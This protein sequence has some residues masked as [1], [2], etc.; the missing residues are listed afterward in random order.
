MPEFG[1]KP[2]S[3]PDPN[4]SPDSLEGPDPARTASLLGAFKSG[5]RVSL[6]PNTRI[7]M[8]QYTSTNPQLSA[9]IVNTL[10]RTYIE[11]SYT[12]KFESTMKAADW[13]TKQLVDVKM[14]VETSQEKLVKYQ[15]EHEILGTDEK[16]NIITEKLGELNKELTAAESERMEK[17]VALPL[18]CKPGDADAVAMR[19]AC[20]NQPGPAALPLLR[21]FWRIC[22]RKQADLKIQIAELGT[23]FGPAYPK[24]AQLNG[25]L[26]EIDRQIQVETEQNRRTALSGQY[27]TAFQQETMLRAQFEK[28]KQ[29][30]NKLNESA[31]EYSILKREADTN[32]QLYEG[33]MEKLKEASVTAGLKSSNIRAWSTRTR[34]HCSERTEYPAQ[35]CVCSGARP[36]LRHRP[37]IP[38]REH[39]QHRAHHRA[40][41]D[42]F[43]TA[44][45]G[46]DSARICEQRVA[47]GAETR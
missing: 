26:K 6:K 4:L 11:Q 3:A 16:Q 22:A 33:L 29:E 27:L 5:L 20:S 7:V 46:H 34:S 18:D 47:H 35:P 17:E 13:L 14:N 43:R 1:G 2:G 24:V 39:G 41:P 30:A 23:Q 40:G 25:Q 37:R 21:R 38:A 36:H 8:I 12:S 28:Q 45:A 9:S 42:D 10:A 15:K 19:P 44:V 32:R 31:I